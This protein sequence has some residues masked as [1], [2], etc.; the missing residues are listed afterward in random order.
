M[1]R[2]PSEYQPEDQRQRWLKY[3]SNVAL[4]CL[5]VIVLAALVTYAAERKP[6]RLD[7]TATGTESVMTMSVVEPTG[8]GS[9]KSMTM[10]IGMTRIGDCPS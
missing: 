7:T 2:N 9:D 4:V 6:Y 3:G 5:V 1:S 8:Q 10:K